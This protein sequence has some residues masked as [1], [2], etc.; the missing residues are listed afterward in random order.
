MYEENMPT[1]FMNLLPVSLNFP[2][3]DQIKNKVARTYLN[4]GIYTKKNLKI[5]AFVSKTFEKYSKKYS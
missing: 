2:R 1:V 4:L 5:H 3:L